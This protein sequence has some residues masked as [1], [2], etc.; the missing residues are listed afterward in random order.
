MSFKV[1]FHF[2]V[3]D[4]FL[5]TN[6]VKWHHYPP[7]HF[8]PFDSQKRIKLPNFPSEVY[9]ELVPNLQWLNF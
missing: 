5:S 4:Y 1:L 2:N 7:T 9:P 3:L 8:D 6:L